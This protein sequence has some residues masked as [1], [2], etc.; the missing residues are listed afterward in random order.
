MKHKILFTLSILQ[1]CLC[2]A[3]PSWAQT[4]RITGVIIDAKNEEPLIG[5]S[6]Y[7]E[8]L[9]RGDAAG[10]NGEFTLNGLAAGSYEAAISYMGYHTQHER[11]TLREGETKK[12]IVRLKAETQSLGEITVTA[13]SEARKLREQAMPVTVLSAAQLAG[14]VSDVTDIL[15]KTMGVT[16]RTQGGVGSASRLSVRGL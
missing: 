5:A 9:K 2:M 14:S 1:V 8:Q 12:L 7:I 13:K 3:L 6:I 16:I 10:Q 11:I 15:S 4:A